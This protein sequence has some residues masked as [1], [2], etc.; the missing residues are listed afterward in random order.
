M[1]NKPVPEASLLNKCSSLAVAL[2]VIKFIA[3]IAIVLVTLY[4][5]AKDQQFNKPTYEEASFIKKAQ[6]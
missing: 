4:C 5:A 3:F 2:G 1:F 6:A